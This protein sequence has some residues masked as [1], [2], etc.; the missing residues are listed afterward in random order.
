MI[1]PRKMTFQLTPLLD[2]L[3]IV[4]FAQFMEVEQTSQKSEASLQNRAKEIHAKLMRERDDWKARMDAFYA[5]RQREI[6]QQKAANAVAFK[7]MA[8]QHSRSGDVLA[9]LFNLSEDRIRE[10]LKPGGEGQGYT[11]EQ[12]VRI[13]RSL[14]TIQEKKGRELVRLLISFG[15]MEKRCDLWEIHVT[16]TGTI[17]FDNG[18]SVQE[19]EAKTTDAI[20][21][22]L[23]DAY[24]LSS[25]PKT[26]VI[27]LF[28]YAARA[29]AGPRQ[30]T[31]RALPGALTRM[32]EDSGGRNW[33]EFAVLGFTPEGPSL[34]A[35]NR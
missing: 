15:E 11:K 34:R 8:E 6:D 5:E 1:L 29:G 10:L 14:K 26:L 35:R 9:E 30:R 22:G 18:E 16:E 12:E 24:K 19:L 13:R 32:R 21:D 7:S 28:S 25:E 20:E 17:E 4:I 31:E 27:L 23:F 3:L 33:F 2:L